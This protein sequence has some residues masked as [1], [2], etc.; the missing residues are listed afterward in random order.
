VHASVAMMA[1]RGADRGDDWVSRRCGGGRRRTAKSN[2]VACDGGIGLMQVMPAT[3][4]YVNQRFERNYDINR[5]TDNAVSWA[6][7]T[8]PG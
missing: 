5:Y 8:S 1:F 6:P 3:A 4:D 2:I 7:I